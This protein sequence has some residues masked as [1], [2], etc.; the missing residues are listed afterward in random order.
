MDRP[1]TNL[2]TKLMEL[3]FENVLPT[4]FF[5]IQ[6]RNS[7]NLYDINVQLNSPHRSV[8]VVLSK[9]LEFGIRII[10]KQ[11][12]GPIFGSLNKNVFPPWILKLHI[13]A[14]Q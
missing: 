4:W 10:K 9:F 7:Y 1:I 12:F 5:K 14:D 3:F 6:I 11:Y 2:L 13:R 8:T